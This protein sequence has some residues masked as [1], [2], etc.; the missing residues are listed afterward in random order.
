MEDNNET[1]KPP[2]S[3]ARIG[4]KIATYVL[5]FLAVFVSLLVWIAS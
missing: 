1:S 5:L 3:E 4:G 2:K